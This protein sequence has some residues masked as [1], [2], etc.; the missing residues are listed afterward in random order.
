MAGKRSQVMVNKLL[1]GGS[2]KR[3]K[4]RRTG[5]TRPG[6]TSFFKGYR[7]EFPGRFEGGAVIM[8]APPE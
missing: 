8:R 6:A 4:D 1:T 7:P 5:P 2:G 3:R